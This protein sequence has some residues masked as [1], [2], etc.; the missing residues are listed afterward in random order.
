MEERKRR[1]LHAIVKDYISTAEPVGSRTIARKYNLGVSPATI[2]NE[3]ADLEDLGYIEQPHTSAGRIPSNKG[4]RFYVDC[5]MGK[6]Q[7]SKTEE[8][9]IFSQLNQ[10]M[11][12][13]EKVIA[14]ASRVLSKLSNYTAVVVGPLWGSSIFNYVKMLS[15]EKDKA[16][17]VIVNNIGT[18]EHKTIDLPP[19]ISER[20]LDHISYVLNSKLQGLAMEQVKSHI[21]NEIYS[22]LLKEKLFVKTIL[23]IIENTLV[24][25]ENERVFLDGTV[26]IL[27]QP[28]FKNIE[29][30]KNLLSILEEKDVLIRLIGEN[31]PR[32]LTIRIGEENKI[33]DIKDCSLITA[34]YEIDNE[35][36]GSIGILGP[37]RMQYSKSTA[38]VEYITEILSVS[39]SR[40]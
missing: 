27:N 36:I 4:Y 39:L 3:M 19:L 34:T 30:V 10:K 12:D 38:L 13:I 18:V 23:E 14:N 1:V 21:F 2:R 17:L 35:I 28:E 15:M 25:V 22:E 24:N 32:G 11:E 20:D 40:K 6:Y 7:L 9:F 5:I 33:D 29:K 16:L 31:K 26:N 37:T 8:E